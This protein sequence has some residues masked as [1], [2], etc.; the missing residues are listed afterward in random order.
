[1]N[2]IAAL[3]VCYETASVIKIRT[4]W[5]A[6]IRRKEFPTDTRAVP[7]RGLASAW[8]AAIEL[9]MLASKHQDASIISKMTLADLMGKQAGASRRCCR[10]PGW[11]TLVLKLVLASSPLRLD[12]A[13][14]T[15]IHKAT[16]YANETQY[17]K[18]SE[19]QSHFLA[20]LNYMLKMRYLV[21]L[22]ILP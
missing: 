8:A 10:Q 16:S 22:V 7:T 15:R 5:R 6:Q 19:A 14:R 20:I 3:Q 2:H 11:C 18:R 12:G 9:N 17:L 1:M 4:Q 21:N 13:E